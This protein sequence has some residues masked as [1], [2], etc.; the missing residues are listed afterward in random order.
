[1]Y[2]PYEGPGYTEPPVNW[3]GWHC[4]HS[5]YEKEHYWDNPE[6]EDCWSNVS[7]RTAPD[8]DEDAGQGLSYESEPAGRVFG[9]PGLYREAAESSGP[10]IM[11]EDVVDPP[12]MRTE[13]FPSADREAEAE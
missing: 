12:G 11:A 1:M 10:M 2:P 3:E 7:P 13:P 5:K 6:H 4:P 8:A 9:G